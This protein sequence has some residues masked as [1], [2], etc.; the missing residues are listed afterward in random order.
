MQI[1]KV[2]HVNCKK[3]IRGCE[4]SPNS[5][6][7]ELKIIKSNEKGAIINV[8]ELNL[9]PGRSL[10]SI[11]KTATNWWE[12]DLGIPSYVCAYMAGHNQ[13]TRT[14]YYEKDPT[15]EQLVN[16]HGKKVDLKFVSSSFQGNKKLQSDNGNNSKVLVNSILSELSNN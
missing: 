4:T 11:R 1:I 16:M 15:A 8:K 6:L 3:K 12:K 10:H 13:Q 5:I 9:E 14:K 7:E 2:G